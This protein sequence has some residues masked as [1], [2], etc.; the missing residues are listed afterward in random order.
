[1]FLHDL[2]ASYRSARSLG[3]CPAAATPFQYADYVCSERERLSG[4]VF[5][6]QTGVWRE[7]LRDAPQFFFDLPA[8]TPSAEAGHR[9]ETSTFALPP[10]TSEMLASMGR[11]AHATPFMTALTSVYA[12]LLF[13]YTHQEDVVIGTPVSMR[14]RPELENLMGVW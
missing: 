12:A 14:N 10:S 9:G 8:T 7:K 1:M 4:P 3:Y 6:T 5:G 13:R 2:H 11:R